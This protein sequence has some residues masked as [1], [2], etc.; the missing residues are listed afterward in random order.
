MPYKEKDFEKIYWPISEVAEQLGVN[1]SLI[2]Y[3]ETEFDILR[4]SK[5][6]KGDRSFTKRDVEIINM[7]YHLVKEKGYTLEG[8]KRIIKESRKN[9]DESMQIR[10]SLIKLRQFLVEIRQSL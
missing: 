2:R 7:I 6:Q 8:A 5:N 3:W 4:P 9:V 10:S 1:T